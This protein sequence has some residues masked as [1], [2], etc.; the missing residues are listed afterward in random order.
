MVELSFTREEIPKISRAGGS[1][2]EAEP[3]EQHLGSLKDEGNKGT[4]FRVWTYD[5]RPSA[6]SRMTSVRERLSKAVPH[7]NW[8]LAVRPTPE[9]ANKFGVYVMYDGNYTPEQITEN[10]R[11][12]AERSKRVSESREAAKAKRAAEATQAPVEDAP[13]A[14][15]SAKERVAAAAKNKVGASK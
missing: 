6:T 14:E 13:A 10:A 7:E 2:R 1:G 9:D 8:K 11:K 4:S 5:K 15:P 3:W 12:H